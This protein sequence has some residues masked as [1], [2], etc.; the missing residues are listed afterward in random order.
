MWD[1]GK[2][3]SRRGKDTEASF[4]DRRAVLRFLRLQLERLP[5]VRAGEWFDVHHLLAALE[6]AHAAAGLADGERDR[7]G[8]LADA[9]GGH[10]PAAEAFPHGDT[11]CPRS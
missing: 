10:V 1:R 4:F 2:S 11:V 6:H 8:L 3:L 9:G 7:T 5:H